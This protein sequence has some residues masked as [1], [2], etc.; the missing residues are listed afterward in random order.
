MAYGVWRTDLAA[1]SST[2]RSG[3]RPDM[4]SSDHLAKMT[5][6]RCEGV[7][8]PLFGPRKA[9]ADRAVHGVFFSVR[10]GP[11]RAAAKGGIWQYCQNASSYH[12]HAHGLCT[13]PVWR[14]FAAPSTSD[15]RPAVQCGI[16]FWFGDVPGKVRSPSACHAL[17]GNVREREM[18]C[19]LFCH[20]CPRVPK[21]HWVRG[22]GSIGRNVRALA[23][24]SR[25]RWVRE[26]GRLHMRAMA[27]T[28][29][30]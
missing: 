19:Q 27:A 15:C 18:S 17:I 12:L 20:M 13:G 29:F 30:V 24:T 25:V 10:G 11:Q 6:Q 9:L 23:T 16:F 22:W 14:K 7:D 2:P 26:W 8:T 28:M 4:A 3:H 1:T 21:S 5:P